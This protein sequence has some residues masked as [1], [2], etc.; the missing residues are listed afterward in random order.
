MKAVF[1]PAVLSVLSV[2]LSAEAVTSAEFYPNQGYQFG[3]FEARI[4]F[5]AGDGVISSFFL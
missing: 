5:G 4:Q 2:A 3:R 1:L